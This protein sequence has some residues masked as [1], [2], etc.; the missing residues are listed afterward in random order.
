MGWVAPL[1]L[2]HSAVGSPLGEH[3]YNDNVDV[4]VELG[5]DT[6][7]IPRDLATGSGTSSWGGSGSRGR[8][9]SGGS[10]DFFASFP[11]DRPARVATLGRRKSIEEH[12]LI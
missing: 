3:D 7:D 4:D 8:L 12:S 10:D 2:R 6:H 9:D 5:F 1:G 11:V